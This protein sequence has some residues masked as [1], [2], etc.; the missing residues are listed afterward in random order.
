M[1]RDS[2]RSEGSPR[3]NLLARAVWPLLSGMWVARAS[4]PR[5]HS[6]GGVRPE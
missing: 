4:V 2:A 6:L 3:E 1:R 5:R